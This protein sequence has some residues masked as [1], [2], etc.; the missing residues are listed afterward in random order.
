MAPATLNG[1]R[2]SAAQAAVL[3]DVLG[4]SL[5]ALLSRATNANL[6]LTDREANAV[7]DA[8][9]DEFCVSGL[10]PNDEPNQRGLLLE[11]LID[12]VNRRARER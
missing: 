6:V 5:P 1:T 11:S 12:I 4:R 10:D 3:A 9:L 7:L 2:L 8:C